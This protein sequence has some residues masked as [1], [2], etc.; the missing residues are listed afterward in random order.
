MN[1]SVSLL[2]KIKELGVANFMLRPTSPLPFL[3]LL[4]TSSLELQAR[5]AFCS[6][7]H[8]ASSY[9]AAWDYIDTMIQNSALRQHG[10]DPAQR[11]NS[12][13]ISMALPIL[14]ALLQ[15]QTLN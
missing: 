15:G 10:S 5:A 2:A 3:Q 11:E 4:G 12:V 13:R 7:I 9:K 6:F 8:Q 14:M 1:L